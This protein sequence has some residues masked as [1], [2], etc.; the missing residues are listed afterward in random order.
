MAFPHETEIVA[1]DVAVL[2][3]ADA[4]VVHDFASG[5]IWLFEGE[6]AEP[7]RRADLERREPA[8]GRSQ[9]PLER[10]PS[11]TEAAAFD[12]VVRLGQ[13]FA[14]VRC[15]PEPLS[16]TFAG[17]LAPILA[18]GDGTGPVIDMFIAA[19]G[20]PVV[21]VDG[22]IVHR[23]GS[24]GQGRWL[25]LRQLALQLYPERSW[26][27]VLHGATIAFP[28]GGAVLLAAASGSG[29]TTLAGAFL[30][31][32]GQ[33]LSD[34]I[35]PLEAISHAVWPFP[36]AMSVKSGSWDVFGSFH[37]AFA[38]TSPVRIVA[39]T[40]RYFAAPNAISEPAP[41][42]LLAI[43]APQFEAGSA[44]VMEPLEPVALFRHLIASGSW[45]TEDRGM[46]DDM[47]GWLET[48]P[49]FQIRYGDAREAARY[50]RM[51]LGL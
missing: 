4:V 18:K 19:D 25:A 37:A 7:W 40:V 31:D 11:P 45:P 29:K 21:T 43:V 20:Q 1:S 26:L 3:F 51:T 8:P 36:L 48:V 42:P 46:L 5:R 33:L 13:R 17:A 10:L 2:P 44:V 24:A 12:E 49:A 6:D 47:L 34:D 9:L 41:Y 30:A 50:V 28:S 39:S 35:S 16:L 27:A 22:S 38:T 14:R 23:P 32:G 15:W